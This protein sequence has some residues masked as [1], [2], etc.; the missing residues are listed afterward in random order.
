[1]NTELPDDHTERLSRARLA[2]DG[3][4]V[5]DAFGECFFGNPETISRRIDVRQAP[6]LPWSYTDDT[7]MA[8]SVFQCL[9]EH[10][11]IDRDRLAE[12]FAQEYMREPRRGYG[13][14]AHSILRAIAAG[15]SWQEATGSAFSGT[16]SMGNGAAMRVAP[17]GAYFSDALPLLI[18]H[19]SFSA[20]V[21]HAHPEGQVGAVAVALASAWAWNHREKINTVDTREM[22]E[23][24]VANIPPGDTHTGIRRG[25]GIPFSRTPEVAAHTLGNGSGVIAPDTVPLTIWCAARHF[26][27]YNEAIWATV[28]ACGDID[29]NCAIV[30]GIVALSAGGDSIP[31]EWLSARGNLPLP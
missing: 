12:L 4:S 10:G 5:G 19:A 16:G 1:M 22:I 14:T 20:E 29:T 26:G 30:G 9:S 8:L 24:V 3:L 21:T 11:G 17:L 7:A 18:R 15:T 25:L 31:G 6:P 23:F 28:S 27:N 2:L 13:G